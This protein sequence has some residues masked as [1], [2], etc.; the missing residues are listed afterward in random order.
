M[1]KVLSWNNIYGIY[2]VAEQIIKVGAIRYI[3]DWGWEELFTALNSF[4]D[5]K[6][7]ELNEYLREESLIVVKEEW[8]WISIEEYRQKFPTDKGPSSVFGQPTYVVKHLYTESSS[9]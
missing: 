4:D 3:R 5:E 2:E 9:N 8:K 1:H 6:L 7:S